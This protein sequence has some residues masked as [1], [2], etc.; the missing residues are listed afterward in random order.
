MKTVGDALVQFTQI[1]NNKKRDVSIKELE[2]FIAGWTALQT[3][4]L[5]ENLKLMD[6]SRPNNSDSP[7]E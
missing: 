1:Q 6:I 5:V 7:A 4:L 3:E 2:A